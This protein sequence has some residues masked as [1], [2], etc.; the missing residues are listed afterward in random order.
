ML[1]PWKKSYNK[2]RNE[3]DSVMSDYL[4]PHG[5]YS[6]WNSPGQNTGVGS[7]S[8]LQGIFQTQG[9]NPGLPHCRWIHYQL[10][11]QG[12]LMTNLNSL[13]KSRDI[14]LS[15]KVQLVKAMVFPVF[16]GVM[17]GCE[18]WTSER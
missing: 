15:T 14:T 12:S 16:P 10:S 8:F 4:Q 11:H 6:P 3:S 1:A 9:L 2:P 17:Y 13:L 18:N 7:L 5:L